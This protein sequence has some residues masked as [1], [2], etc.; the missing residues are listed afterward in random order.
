MKK[1]RKFQLIDPTPER[2]D[3]YEKIIPALDKS[4]GLH[5]DAKVLAY[6]DRRIIDRFNNIL[7]IEFHAETEFDFY[8]IDYE[9]IAIYTKAGLAFKMVSCVSESVKEIYTTNVSWQLEPKWQ[10]RETWDK[11]MNML[12]I[13]DSLAGISGIRCDR[14]LYPELFAVTLK[15][16]FIDWLAFSDYNFEIGRVYEKYNIQ[17]SSVDLIPEHYQANLFDDILELTDS[18]RI[19]AYA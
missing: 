18:K 1:T 9:A 6:S 16:T 3:I 19:R 7:T 2:W 12:K 4:Y 13:I 11:W 14:K 15:Y 17:I 10:K 5:S 8:N